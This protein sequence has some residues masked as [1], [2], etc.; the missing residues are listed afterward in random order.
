MVQ[1]V[2]EDGDGVRKSGRERAAVEIQ[3]GISDADCIRKMNLVKARR[4]RA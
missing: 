2:A 4:G 1:W 3:Q